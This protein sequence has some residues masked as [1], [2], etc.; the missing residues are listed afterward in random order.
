MADRRETKVDVASADACS[1]L[2]SETMAASQSLRA[3]SA[4]D[5]TAGEDEGTQELQMQ[6]Q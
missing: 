3:V 2:D 4:D 5:A 6:T 1:A